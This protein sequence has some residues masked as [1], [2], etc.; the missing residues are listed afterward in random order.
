MRRGGMD[1]LFLA[2]I[3]AVVGLAVGLGAYFDHL[4]DKK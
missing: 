2:L 1:F 4:R 3:F